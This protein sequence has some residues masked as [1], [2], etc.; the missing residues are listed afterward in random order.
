MK[1]IVATVLVATI[2][3]NAIHNPQNLCT[4]V[5]HPVRPICPLGQVAGGSEGCWGCCQP[6]PT[7]CMDVCH[8]NKPVCPIGQVPTGQ[9]G[10][11]GCCQPIQTIIP[12]ILPPRP[13]PLPCLAVCPENDIVC[14]NRETTRTEGCHGCCPLPTVV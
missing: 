5:C 11:W 8:P 13:T 6:V 7:A 12:T 14:P 9:E 2:S 10:C 1:L 4:T 3:A